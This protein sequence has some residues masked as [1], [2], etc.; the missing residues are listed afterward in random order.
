MAR[1][2][3]TTHSSGYTI[4][5]VDDQEEVLSSTRSI[6]EWAGHQVVTAQGGQEA[7][8]LFQPGDLHLILP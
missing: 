5:V 7:L 6:L 4:L 3:T 2:R 1:K 8:R